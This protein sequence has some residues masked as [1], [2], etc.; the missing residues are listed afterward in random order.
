MAHTVVAFAGHAPVSMRRDLARSTLRSFVLLTSLLLC[1]ILPATDGGYDPGFAQ[2]GRRVQMLQGGVVGVHQ[3]QDRSILLAGGCAG[4]DTSGGIV[5]TQCAIGLTEDG[6]LS[7]YGPAG[8]GR[9]LLSSLL[10]QL[11]GENYSAVDSAADGAGRLVIVG[12]RTVGSSVRATIFRFSTDGVT[13][14]GSYLRN[15]PPGQPDF[16]LFSA[17]AIDPEGRLLAAGLKKNLSGPPSLL[18]TRFGDDLQIDPGFGDQGSAVFQDLAMLLLLVKDLEVDSQGRILVLTDSDN[19]FAPDDRRNTIFR[20]LSD[21]TLDTS[22]GGTGVVMLGGTTNA[23]AGGIALDQLDRVLI[24]GSGFDPGEADRDLHLARLMP[25][26]NL[27]GDFNSIPGSGGGLLRIEAENLATL[28]LNESPGDVVVQAN[29]KLLLVGAA[30]RFGASNA[31]YFFTAR[32]LD[33]GQLD[34]DY[35]AGGVSVGTFTGAPSDGFSDR[36]VALAV[37][38]SGRFLV[39]GDSF[40]NASADPE[41]GIARLLNAELADPFIFADEF[42]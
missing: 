3:R 11:P 23:L 26:G 9:L 31:D 21:G 36:A 20:F 19:F 41:F 37:D 10:Q 29:E 7:S 32:V 35:G 2:G 27:D 40:F 39:A 8:D 17:I 34:S 13:L 38:P 22:F 1:E 16:S 28:G 24:L 18:V 30:Q 25:N 4:T 42:E 12:A 6:E 5:G 14:A 33:P 15:P